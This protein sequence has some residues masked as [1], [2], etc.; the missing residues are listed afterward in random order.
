[1]TG[2]GENFMTA[3]Q[4]D[5]S[6][7]LLLTGC[8]RSGTTLLEKLLHG[9]DDILMASQAFPALFFHTKEAFLRGQ[10]LDRRYA[11][12]H[13]FLERAYTPYM[14]AAFLDEWG[15]DQNG[16]NA[17]VERLTQD[18]TGLRT[19]EILDHVDRLR[20]DRFWPLFLQFTK[21][22]TDIFPGK[23][24]SRYIGSKEAFTEEFI[25]FFLQHG[26]SVIVI[27]RDPRDVV[28]SVHFGTGDRHMGADRPMLYTLRMWRKSLAYA[29][30]LEDNPNLAWLTY[31]SLV[32]NP[33]ETLSDLTRFL[34]L[35]DYPAHAFKDGIPDQYG[36]LWGGNSSFSA[37]YGIDPSAT[38]KFRSRL[39]EDVTAYVEAVCY[40]ELKAL[41]YPFVALDRFDEAV[42]R[43]FKEP[44]EV[45]HRAF[46]DE[47][48]YSS[49]PERVDRECDRMRLLQDSSPTLS[50]DEQGAWFI[51]PRA[52]N[53]LRDAIR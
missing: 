5:V 47:K 2:P 22:L 17:I 8:F 40:P 20:P 18:S 32:T 11:L 37:S 16:L 3:P 9:H 33:V 44:F 30:A 4:E 34:G 6:R 27:I 49:N 15:V 38:G 28:A 31:E 26:T 19:P 42:I 25:P 43:G 41:G 46:S 45:T 24:S 50:E 21:C 14:F 36:A 53:R 23:A 51:H 29:I 7:S 39:P 48:E 52:F 35:P 13:Q 12:G 1:V 10:G